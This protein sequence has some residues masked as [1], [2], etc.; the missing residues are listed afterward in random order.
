MNATYFVLIA[1]LL[2]FATGFFVASIIWSIKWL[3][4]SREERNESRGSVHLLHILS[5]RL[6]NN[7][8][9]VSGYGNKSEEIVDES[10]NNREL[11]QYY[12]GKN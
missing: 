4:L 7:E 2:T 6:S 12:H 3:I 5:K 10:I 11:Y 9:A 8:F 1:A